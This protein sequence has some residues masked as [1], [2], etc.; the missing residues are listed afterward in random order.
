MLEQPFLLQVAADGL[1]VEGVK[2]AGVLVGLAQV[3]VDA[4]LSYLVADEGNGASGSRRVVVAAKAGRL[5]VEHTLSTHPP[6]VGPLGHIELIF[7]LGMAARAFLKGEGGGGIEVA[8]VGLLHVAAER[9]QIV[10]VALQLVAGR[11]EAERRVVS[12]GPPDAL[13]LAVEVGFGLGIGADV[14]CPVGQLHLQVEPHLVGHAESSLRRAVGMEA[15]GV[16]SPRLGS[17]EHPA[18]ALLGGGRTARE[19]EDAALERGAQ[20]DALAVE[21]QPAVAA[22]EPAHAET[23][24]ALP[25]VGLHGEPIYIRCELA[26]E[27]GAADGDD[28]RGVVRA[29][30][31]P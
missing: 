22:L 10:E 26:P 23:H 24:R 2:G 3:G 12:V 14:E 1:E 9:V 19:G 21:Q 13:E 27:P 18:P 17:A 29:G 5:L 11:H 25:A 6:A 31:G 20:E 28:E 4:V 7:G 16:K 30:V 15:Q 8:R